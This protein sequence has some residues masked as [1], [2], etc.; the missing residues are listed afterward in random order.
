MVVPLIVMS[1][2]ERLSFYQLRWD[3]AIPA[4]TLSQVFPVEHLSPLS[5]LSP[6]QLPPCKWQEGC[7]RGRRGRTD[8]RADHFNSDSQIPL[9][10]ICTTSLSPT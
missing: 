10:Q 9:I 1:G 3:V 2:R 4:F 7:G 8:G 6:A 5:F